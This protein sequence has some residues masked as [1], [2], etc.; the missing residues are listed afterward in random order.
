[1]IEESRLPEA[2]EFRSRNYCRLVTKLRQ[3]LA[4]ALFQ[5]AFPSTQSHVASNANK[6][7]NMIRHQDITPGGNV[8]LET[9]LGLF[10]KR[11][12]HSIGREQKASQQ[13]VERDEI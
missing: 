12:K 10:T 5:A 11:A 4:Q 13:R 3:G 8:K 1:M 6:D 2:F 7:V 9:A